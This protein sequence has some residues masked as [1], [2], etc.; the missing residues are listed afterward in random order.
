MEWTPE[1]SAQSSA[2]PEE[3]PPVPPPAPIRVPWDL[4]NA[5]SVPESEVLGTAASVP[6][7][8]QVVPRPFYPVP[9]PGEE[10]PPP[11]PL[12][13]RVLPRKFDTHPMEPAPTLEEVLYVREPEWAQWTDWHYDDYIKQKKKDEAF[14]LFC[15]LMPR[16]YDLTWDIF[17]LATCYREMDEHGRKLDYINFRDKTICFI[18]RFVQDGGV[19]FLSLQEEVATIQAHESRGWLF[20]GEAAEQRQEIMAQYTKCLNAI[21]HNAS[22]DL[23][24]E[25]WG[26][27]F[28]DGPLW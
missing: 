22:M 8:E 25:F 24:P 14:Y 1:P 12:K 26:S 9:P 28:Y 15:S 17:P 5:A 6:L 16:W 19:T 2:P 23:G 10:L 11:T 27:I 7:P 4:R 3:V 20:I 18:E 21:K 13:E